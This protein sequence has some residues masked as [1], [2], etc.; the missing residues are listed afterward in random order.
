MGR[1]KTTKVHRGT[2]DQSDQQLHPAEY[3]SLEQG[4]IHFIGTATVLIRY[5]GFTVLTDP[6][7]LHR[8][9]RVHLG[10]GLHST[11]RTDPAMEIEDLPPL[12]VVLLSHMHEDH[13]DRIAAERLDRRVPLVTTGHAAVSLRR[14]GFETVQALRTWDS[15]EMEKQGVKLR[16]TSMPG[17][18][19][20]GVVGWL[21]PP[22]MGSMLEFVTPTGQTALRLYISG[23]TLVHDAL[24]EIPRRYPEIDIGLLH[25]GGTRILGM[26]VTMDDK[27]GVEAMR[28]VNPHEAIPIHYDDYT[29]FKSPLD[30]FKRSVEAAGLEERVRYLNRG[31]SYVFEV[32]RTRL[33]PRRAATVWSEARP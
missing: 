10:Y 12:D 2:M 19:G 11:R 29:V 1:T 3:A 6:N 20:P 33:P 23:D 25:L 21:L 32:P 5:G 8:G 4:S 27:Q 26:L 28:I 13:F 14:Q 9:D 17:R 18:H 16:V 7:F 15:V 31:Q 22:V 30:A 24:H